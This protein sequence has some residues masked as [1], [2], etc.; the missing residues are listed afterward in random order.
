MTCQCTPHR[1]RAFTLIELLVVVAVIA[2]LIGLLLPALGRARETAISLQCASN[3]RQIGIGH[4]EWAA[5]NDDYII[6]PYIP[7]PVGNSP[8][9]RW[10]GNDTDSTK[11]WWQIM[12]DRLTDRATREERFESFRCPAWKPQYSNEDLANPDADDEG[13]LPEQISFR[14]GYGMNRRLLAPD[15]WTRYHIPLSE[16]PESLQAQ[17]DRNRF[18]P[19]QLLASVISTGGDA[20]D[21]S[22]I[23]SDEY[24]PAPWRF[25]RVQFPS[26][27]VINGDSGGPWLDV[28]RKV[29][30]WSVEA[31]FEGDPEASGDPRRHSGG[32][33][34]T[35]P[36]GMDSDGLA[37]VP[38]DLLTGTANYLHVDGH[39]RSLESLEA[40][41]R[42]MDPTGV[43]DTVE[44]YLLEEGI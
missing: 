23:N 3:Q 21:V 32:R 31:D 40:V 28:G 18:S 1:T 4:F 26:I 34:R 37:I 41:Q 11:F 39:V 30:F 14:S 12:S 2:L 22:E 6:W 8:A 29:P 24:V 19:G 33:Y 10:E 16:V 38:E 20:S 42:V 27:R 35:E 44:E 36:G 13:I 17:I 7:E 43:V 9:D 25:S 5:D 15:N